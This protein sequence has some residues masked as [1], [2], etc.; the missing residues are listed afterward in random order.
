MNDQPVLPAALPA[1]TLAPSILEDLR[2]RIGAID[3]QL[4]ALLMRRAAL[5]DAIEALRHE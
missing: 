2:R 4:H 3:D 5:L 1:D